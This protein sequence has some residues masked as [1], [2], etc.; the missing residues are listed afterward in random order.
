MAIKKPSEMTIQELN[1]Y[2][3]VLQ[4]E[5]EKNKKYGLIWDREDIVASQII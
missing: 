2:I 1:D 5:L 3:S 4:K